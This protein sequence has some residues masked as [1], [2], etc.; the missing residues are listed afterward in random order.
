MPF[1]GEGAG[2]FSGW[3]DGEGLMDVAAFN[4]QPESGIGDADADD[5]ADDECA[6]RVAR[7][8]VDVVVV[9]RCVCRPCSFVVY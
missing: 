1:H 5:G 4:D 6:E 7:V 2:A 8:A 3:L 9:T